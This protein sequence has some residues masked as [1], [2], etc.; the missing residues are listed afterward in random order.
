MSR[1]GKFGSA[2][3]RIPSSEEGLRPALFKSFGKTSPVR[4]FQNGENSMKLS[5]FLRGV[6]P[7]VGARPRPRTNAIPPRMKKGALAEC[8]LRVCISSESVSHLHRKG[9]MC[10][11]IHAGPR[12]APSPGWVLV[13]RPRVS[14]NPLCPFGRRG[15]ST[16]GFL[17]PLRGCAFHGARGLFTR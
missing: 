13:L 10:P 17:A 5:P 6:A 15:T 3:L 8:A 4:F 1:N 14:M 16:H 7:A 12:G 9:Q 11:E 2:G